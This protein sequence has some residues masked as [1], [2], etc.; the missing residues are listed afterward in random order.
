MNRRV[1]L[2]A[3]AGPFFVASIFVQAAVRNGFDP[4]EHPPSAL[5]LG[6][7]GWIQTSTFLITG[8]AFLTGATGLRG[9]SVR[10]EGRLAPSFA[11]IFA[12]ALIAGGSF[13]MDPAFGFPPGTPDGIGDNVSWHAALHGVVFPLGFLSVLAT[14]WSISRRYAV[15]DRTMMRWVAIMVGPLVLALSMWPNI[16]G[17]PQGRFLTLWLGVALAFLWMSSI[18]A[19]SA[20]RVDPRSVA[21]S[22]RT[23]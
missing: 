10:R 1:L 8:I 21:A 11:T 18:F 23:A 6:A 19:D 4:A 13:P 7:Q 5:A 20:R 14:G 17:D 22:E 12:L 16:T 15:T 3:I 2:G 9:L